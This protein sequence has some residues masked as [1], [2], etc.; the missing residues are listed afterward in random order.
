MK[1]SPPPDFSSNRRLILVALAVTLIAS[2]GVFLQY[3]HLAATLGDP[4][5]AMRLVLVRDL[6]AG[7]GWYDQLVTRLQPPVGTYM[8]WSRLVDAP[9]AGM[10]WTFRLVLPAPVAEMAV[11]LFWPL[12]LIFP[13]VVCALTIAR[14]LG[15]SLAV[16]VCA[17]LLGVN[18]LAFGEF[19]PGRIDHHNIQIT[20]VMI[21][22]A[23][24]MAGERRSSWALL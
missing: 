1:F 2:T 19:V 9:L 14:R 12:F 4:D 8:H 13:A 21:A 23:C 6:M 18:Q 7:R 11:R 24:A 10:I 17:V 22:M 16:F 5:D 15:G 20:L 3:S